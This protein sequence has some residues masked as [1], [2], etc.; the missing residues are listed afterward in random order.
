MILKIVILFLAFMAVLAMF[1][2]LWVLGIGTRRRTC[3][4][5][6]GHVIG[7]SCPCGKTR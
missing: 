3:P 1:G 2:K 4:D 7:D 6:K 5:C